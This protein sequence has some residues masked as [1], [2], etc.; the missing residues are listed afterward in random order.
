MS[1]FIAYGTIDMAERKG[2]ETDLCPDNGHSWPLG[3]CPERSR[4]I[5]L[6]RSPILPRVV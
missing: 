1:E 5:A 3:A 6:E 2:T 4:R